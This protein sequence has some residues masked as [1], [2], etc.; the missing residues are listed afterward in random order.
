LDDD[1]EP[2]VGA[3]K[4]TPIDWR[5]R[6]NSTIVALLPKVKDQAACG[7]CWAFAAASTMEFSVAIQFKL[8]ANF[9]TQ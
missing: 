4:V 6:L 2:I 5:F 3:Y 1:T 9:S 7:S 8:I